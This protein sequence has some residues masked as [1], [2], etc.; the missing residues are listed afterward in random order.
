MAFVPVMLAGILRTWDVAAVEVRAAEFAERWNQPT[1]ELRIRFSDLLGPDQGRFAFIDGASD[2]TPFFRQTAPGEYVYNGRELPLAPGRR[3]LTVF[4]VKDGQWTELRSLELKVSTESGFEQFDM[5][6]RLDATLKGQLH[7][8]RS[9]SA[10]LF[11]RSDFHQDLTFRGGLGFAAARGD[12]R[13]SSNANAVG[14]TFEPEALRFGTLG[15]HAPKADITDY[16]INAQWGESQFALGHINYGSNPLLLMGYGSRGAVFRRPLGARMDVS[17]NAMNGTSITGAGNILGLDHDE[18]QV[19]GGTLGVELLER[20]GGLRA[21]MQY[22]DASLQ[23]QVPFNSGAVPDAERIRGGGLRMTGASKD[24]R[25]R[26]DFVLARVKHTAVEDPALSQG[27]NLTEIRSETRNA[28]SLDL[29]FD[30]VKPDR[31][32]QDRLPFALNVTIRHERID[33]LFKS[34]GVAFPSDQEYNRIGLGAQLGP[35][36]G[37]AFASVRKD[38]L[39][40]IASILKTQTDISGVAMTLPLAQAWPAQDG[41]PRPWIPSL[42]YRFEQNHQ[43]AIN[44]P[45]GSSFNASSMPDQVSRLQAL[46]ASWQAAAWQLGYSLN[47]STQDNRQPGREAAD[48]QNL[49]HNLTG[50]YRFSQNLGITAGIGRTANFANETA[51]TSTTYSYS[52]GFDWQFR[53]SW[54]LNGNYTRTTG[55]DSQNLA[56]SRGWT[57]QT[58]I[59]KRFTTQPFGLDRRLPG[60]VFLRHMLNDNYNRDNVFALLNAGRFWML[61]TGVTV[62]FF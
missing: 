7:Q 31:A 55:Q 48:F 13:V 56:E 26:G 24:G 3:N 33:P 6:P 30:L 39:E 14:S 46:G 4:L 34:V 25:L 58:Q 37:Q 23:S 51:L 52:G 27:R 54:G 1:A 47:H 17:V 18:H 45:V 62:S 38:N 36:Q 60:Q 42:T 22:L 28:R 21:E 2:L 8:G 12:F 41:A 20:R 10:P 40:N 49:G 57:M 9:G 11:T 61:Q 29:A 15:K 35:L 19:R 16:I 5:R 44:F 43:R 53:E 59:T 32:A 50:G